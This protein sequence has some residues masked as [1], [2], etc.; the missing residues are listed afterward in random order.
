MD[1]ELERNTIIVVILFKI[2]K[3]GPIMMPFSKKKCLLRTT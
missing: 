1:S 2:S 3:K